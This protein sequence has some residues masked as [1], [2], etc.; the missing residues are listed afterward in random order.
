MLNF[1]TNISILS[2]IIK[3][4][5]NK[6]DS[7]GSVAYEKLRRLLIHGQVQSG[8]KLIE[9]DW[10]RR[11]GVHRIAMRE[12]MVLLAHEGL[13][14]IG[15][16]G[17]FFTP[18]LEQR[19]LDEIMEARLIIEIGAIRLIRKRGIDAADVAKLESIC[20][21]MQANLDAEMDLGLIEADRAFHRALVKMS[22]NERLL[23][24][25]SHAPLP[26]WPSRFTGAQQRR[27]VGERTV[28]EHRQIC[29]LIAASQFDDAVDL[30]EKHLAASRPISSFNPKRSRAVKI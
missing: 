23:N 12:A 16:R 27:A 18:I 1:A 30:I 8:I 9:S 5:T 4:K 25:Y 11:L 13:I 19:D 22:G 28:A 17:G 20:D 3:T 15:P 26:L 21:L 6:V 7:P 24:L 14:K 10:A 2:A 29:A